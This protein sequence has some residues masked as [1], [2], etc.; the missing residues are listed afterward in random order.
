MKTPEICIFDLRTE[1]FYL[2]ALW[3][4]RT[5]R[6]GDNSDPRNAQWETTQGVL[7]A[8][9]RQLRGSL[10]HVKR[11]WETTQGSLAHVKGY[12]ALVKGVLSAREGK[13]DTDLA[14][15][16]NTVVAVKRT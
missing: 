1:L 6:T 8:R 13:I 15:V 16:N 5:A 12:L 3:L 7:S 9:G 11:T 14:H 4:L 2:F 10:A